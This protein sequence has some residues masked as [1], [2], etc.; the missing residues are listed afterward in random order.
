V[1]ADG[2][3]T[4]ILTGSPDNLA[5]TAEHGF[6]VIGMKERRL[7]LAEQVEPGDLIVFYVTQL[8]AFGGIVRVTGEMYEDRTKIWPG[9]PGKVD[10]YPWRFAT[11]PV[12]ILAEEDFV[13]AAELAGELEHTRKWPAE[14]WTLAFQ[15]QLRTV[16]DADSRLLDE[17]LREAAGARAAA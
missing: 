10:P 9:K 5:A 17:R 13:P 14:H 4:W 16:S 2:R 6:R 12:L 11:E 8:K 15:G 3:S 1:A 7:G